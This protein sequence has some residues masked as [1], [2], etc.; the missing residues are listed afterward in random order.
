VS[1]AHALFGWRTECP[2]SQE[3]HSPKG[4]RELLPLK[5]ESYAQE[6]RRAEEFADKDEAAAGF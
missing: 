1:F 5:G 2:R 4:V 6:G 3:G